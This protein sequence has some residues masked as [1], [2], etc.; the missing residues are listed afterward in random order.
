MLNLQSGGKTNKLVSFNLFRAYY[1]SIKS[2]FMLCSLSSWCRLACD[3]HGAPSGV[4]FIA[5]VIPNEITPRV[6]FIF[7]SS[8]LSSIF[9]VSKEKRRKKKKRDRLCHNFSDYIWILN[10][11]AKKCKKQIK[12]RTRRKPQN[13]FSSV[14]G[15]RLCSH[16]MTFRFEWMRLF[17]LYEWVGV[18]VI[19]SL[20]YPLPLTTLSRLNLCLMNNMRKNQ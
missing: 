15:L 5:Y 7:I 20:I 4:A 1:R 3:W 11:T 9:S 14:L 12:G 2:D 18:C 19:G 8:S 16:D 6:N 10:E 13:V 17:D